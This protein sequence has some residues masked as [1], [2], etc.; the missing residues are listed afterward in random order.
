MND[1]DARALLQLF[2]ADLTDVRFPDVDRDVL[3]RSLAALAEAS[4]A[5]DAAEAQLL[6]A[7]ARSTERREEL[8]RLC[9][10]AVAYARVYAEATPALAP[11]LD[12]LVGAPRA[13]GPKKRGRPRKPAPEQVALDAAE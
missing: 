5:V 9:R 7:R 8:Q 11:K 10:R 6:V 3:T 1:I 4:A 13:A 2:D 12:A